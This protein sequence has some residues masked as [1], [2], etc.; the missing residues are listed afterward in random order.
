VGVK[1]KVI[2]KIFFMSEGKINIDQVNQMIDSL[3]KEWIKETSSDNLT[4]LNG[5]LKSLY[6]IQSIIKPL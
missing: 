6:I 1:T 4:Y 3:K 5:Q 2:I